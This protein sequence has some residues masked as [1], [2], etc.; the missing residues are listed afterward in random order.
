MRSIGY[1]MEQARQIAGRKTKPGPCPEHGEF[2]PVFYE[3]GVSP[4]FGFWSQC[5]KCDE[6]IALEQEEM[7]ER[8]R[9]RTAE[10]KLEARLN[11]IGIPHRYRTM[12]L[13]DYK[14]YLPAQKNAL[15]WAKAYVQNFRDPR[16]GGRNCLLLGTPGTG[17]TMLCACI[18]MALDRTGITVRFTTMQHAMRRIR[19]TYDDSATETEEHALRTFTN[20]QL[21]V[22]DEIGVQSGSEWERNLAFDMLNERYQQQ[23]PT[24]CI[25]NLDRVGVTQF[26]G[27]RVI[28]RMREGGGKVLLFDWQSYRNPK[29]LTEDGREETDQ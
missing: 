3:S 16:H 9:M 10:E 27:D 20:P 26:L 12:V 24:L 19:S 18:A 14:D 29:A 17:K 4:A 15:A 2:E 13:D 5:P 8:T 11:A 1:L 22:L 6:A 7:H 25:S 23:K 28:D 21:L